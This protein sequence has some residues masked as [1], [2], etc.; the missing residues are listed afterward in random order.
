MRIQ[1]D[2]VPHPEPTPSERRAQRAVTVEL[3]PRMHTF[4]TTKDRC[5]FPGYPKARNVAASGSCVRLV[6]W[7]ACVDDAHKTPQDG[8]A[9]PTW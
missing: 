9:N 7:L 5:T 1:S 3:N 8:I 2:F 6:S 4:G